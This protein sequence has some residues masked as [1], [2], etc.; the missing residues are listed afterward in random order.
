MIFVITCHCIDY[1]LCCTLSTLRNQSTANI[2]R[3]Y[4]SS[5]KK[6]IVTIRN[7]ENKLFY[8]KYQCDIISLQV[9]CIKQIMLEL[10]MHIQHINNKSD[11]I[12][13]LKLR[14]KI[15][16]D[17]TLLLRNTLDTDNILKHAST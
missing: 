15:L 6:Y 8:I 11:L 13:S 4:S 2:C 5:N 14:A 12:R 9:D 7:E 10:C 16:C 3:P 1:V 17:S